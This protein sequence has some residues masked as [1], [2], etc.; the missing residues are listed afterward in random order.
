MTT[1][2]KTTAPAPRD[3]GTAQQQPRLCH[4][5]CGQP[6][7]SKFAQGHDARFVSQLVGRFKAG[8][9]TRAQALAQATKV[10]E[11]LGAKATRS[12]EI[13]AEAKAAEK[14]A[15]APKPEPAP[16]TPPAEPASNAA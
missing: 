11:R 4:C 15:K 1:S 16:A 14:K 7:K 13:A 6:T 8:E 10:S 3:T 2:Q 5:G 12:L 9:L